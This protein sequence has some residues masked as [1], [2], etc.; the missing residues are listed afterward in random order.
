MGR[1]TA[2]EVR[3][4]AQLRDE[5]N[6]FSP[7]LAPMRMRVQSLFPRLA[8]GLLATLANLAPA[9]A[10]EPIPGGATA[11]LESTADA[12]PIQSFDLARAVVHDGV[13][14][15]ADE[16]AKRALVRSPRIA[17]ARA[18]AASS[19]WDAEMQWAAFLPQ[20][21]GYGQYKRVNN[22][23]NQLDLFPSGQQ[24]SGL[25]PAQRALAA[26][27]QPLFS[28][29]NMPNFTAPVNQYAV[30]VSLKYP[31]SDTFL[32]VWP[33][34]DA[35]RSA[36]DSS[37]IQIEVAESLV[38]F[39]ARTLFYDYARA[40]TQLAVA[41]QAVRQAEAQASQ[42]RRFADAGAVAHV[43]LLTATAHLE[44]ARGAEARARSGLTVA[45][46]RLAIAMGTPAQEVSEIAEHVL[47]L[48]A[49]GGLAL[50]PLTSR[51]LERRAELRALR[52]LV[53]ASDQMQLAQKRSALPQL[54]IE[55]ADTYAQ[56]NPRYMPPNRSQFRNS[57]EIG[58][59][60][61]WSPNGTLT[62]WQAGRKAEA[63]GA[64]LR[65]EL[66]SL[67]DQVRGEVVQAY[68]DL[69]SAVAVARATDAQLAAAQEAY[70]VRIEQYRSGDGI[71]VDIL[72]A[73]FALTQAR[74]EHASAVIGAR[75]ALA[76]LERAAVLR[77]R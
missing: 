28:P 4:G 23:N 44:R 18:A 49:E 71:L 3:A 12:A 11:E 68:E 34:Y 36:L 39:E 14:L 10:Q 1:R 50:G 47:D 26:D 35:A 74:L 61:V 19:G 66:A 7:C 21:Q 53:A 58:A 77:D 33:A 20:V 17:S 45:R 56:P 46:T 70:R 25:D 64:K 40:R 65:A 42:I 5:K 24:L 32:R 41:A 13:G 51:A 60:L 48:P 69:Q 57:W 63:A 9:R 29:S 73:D 31:V 38:D 43:D 75:S 59:S 27:L 72:D 16:A 76:A 30:G 67:E 62:G 55:A 52:K 8:L 2:E 54:V 22:V 37:A 15:T 6:L